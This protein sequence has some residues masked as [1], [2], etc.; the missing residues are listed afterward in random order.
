MRNDSDKFHDYYEKFYSTIFFPYL[1]ENGIKDIVQLG[2]LFDRRKYVNFNSLSRARNYF[3]NQCKDRGINLYTLLG[4]HDIFWKESLEVSSSGLLLK[5]YDNIKVYDK[6]EK[7]TLGAVTMDMIPW[8]CRENEEE[9]V[10]FIQQSKSDLCMGHFEIAG[11]A[12]YRGMEAYDGVPMDIFKNYHRVF[13]GHYHTQSQKGNIT[14]AGTPGEITWQ[15]YKDPRGFHVFDDQTLTSTFVQNPYTMFEKIVYDDSD[16]LDTSKSEIDPADYKDKFVKV[17]VVAKNDY[18]KFDI[19]INSLY[20]NGV[21]E[22]KIVEDYSDFEQGE[23]DE[24]IDLED[25]LDV[26]SNYIDRLET[27]ADKT[28]VKKF[29]R[30][31]YVEA[32]NVEVV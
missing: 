6:P 15:D 20:N 17:V 24:G 5:D 28:K 16:P 25:T 23:V 26:L 18:Y 27:D 21:H 4:N 2:D 13:S 30:E 9:V 14:Y 31:L 10:S 19:L 1:E 12:M 32:T 3:F 22:V 29:M 11:F 8:I 7:L